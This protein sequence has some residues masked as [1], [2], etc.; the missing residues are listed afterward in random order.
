M[1]IEDI[2]HSQVFIDMKTK[3][4][5][6]G[7][8]DGIIVH[9][10]IQQEPNM[11]WPYILNNAPNPLSI[12]P[13][14]VAVPTFA[15]IH[16]PSIIEN[17]GDNRDNKRN[18]SVS[19]QM[20]NQYYQLT[21][22][23][24][25][26]HDNFNAFEKERLNIVE[27]NPMIDKI[28]SSDMALTSDGNY[29]L[30]PNSTTSQM[31]NGG[32]SS[33][34]KLPTTIAQ[35]VNYHRDVGK[36]AK[37]DA[38]N[39]NMRPESMLNPWRN[40]QPTSTARLDSNFIPMKESFKKT[41]RSYEQCSDHHS[42]EVA[43]YDYNQIE[44]EFANDLYLRKIPSMTIN[45][46]VIDENTSGQRTSNSRFLGHLVGSFAHPSN[47]QQQ[48]YRNIRN[49]C[50]VKSNHRKV[51][52]QLFHLYETR[53]AFGNLLEQFKVKIEMSEEI[54]PGLLSLNAPKKCLSTD[55]DENNRNFAENFGL[56]LIPE[57]FT[58]K[59]RLKDD[60]HTKSLPQYFQHYSQPSTDIF[61]DTNILRHVCY[62][63]YV[64]SALPTS[65]I[66]ISLK[67]VQDSVTGTKSSGIDI[68][69]NRIRND[70]PEKT[71]SEHSNV[72]M[73]I[74]PTMNFQQLKVADEKRPYRQELVEKKEENLGNTL[75]EL[76][77]CDTNTYS[78]RSA[79]TIP[80][81]S[82][83]HISPGKSNLRKKVRFP[84]EW[85]RALDHRLLIDDLYSI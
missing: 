37:N 40:E 39:Y 72:S 32:V 13:F 83:L 36:A 48:Q 62:S 50:E 75:E 22:K 3:I 30:D 42:N 65:L 26:S 1:P 78:I 77:N 6:Y 18:K 19:Y 69:A 71:I 25:I 49:I 31:S 8:H 46:E 44:E 4:T 70:F 81:K 11:F 59:S 57:K 35:K 52:E 56:S 61:N 38:L 47:Y 12:Q 2:A 34:R 74:C 23:D 43:K 60:K 29:K 58:A 45:T 53:D 67:K 54:Q 10:G 68:S 14:D 82:I 79:G 76:R 5:S 63:P 9:C 16:S 41:A 73:K 84:M 51:P 85:P 24:G 20:P 64:R 17:N 15:T 28:R 33:M 66:P 27:M 21:A 55:Y 80:I 7:P